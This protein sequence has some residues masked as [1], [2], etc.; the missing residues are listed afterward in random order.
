VLLSQ[1][2]NEA[3]V[4]VVGQACSSRAVCSSGQ[5]P[6]ERVGERVITPGQRPW[7]A[8]RRIDPQAPEVLVGS[9]LG[10]A[11]IGMF[12]SRHPRRPVGNGVCCS[13]WPR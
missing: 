4:V 13:R 5:L 6:A 3:S 2:G 10:G 9:S 8:T 11:I 1:G 12:A 7:P